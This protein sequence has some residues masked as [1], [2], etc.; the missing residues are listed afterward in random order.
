MDSS[1]ISL[2]EGFGFLF[3]EDEVKKEKVTKFNI[4]YSNKDIDTNSTSNQIAFILALDIVSAAINKSSDTILTKNFYSSGTDD[5][6]SFFI[7][8]TLDFSKLSMATRNAAS[9]SNVFG[10]TAENQNKSVQTLFDKYS[11]CIKGLENSNISGILL[12]ESESEPVRISLQRYTKMI[13]IL[14]NTAALPKDNRGNKINFKILFDKI[15]EHI[16]SGRLFKQGVDINQEFEELSDHEKLLYGFQEY[17][18][19][20]SRYQ[21][22]NIR[23]NA[24]KTFMSELSAG[25]KN[26][27]VIY[28]DFVGK[29]G[30]RTSGK[31]KRAIEDLT[32]E[33]IS[34]DGPEEL[35]TAVADASSVA[36][37]EADSKEEISQEDQSQKLQYDK[38]DIKANSKISSVKKFAITSAFLLACIE[39]ESSENKSYIDDIITSSPNFSK[40]FKSISAITHPDTSSGPWQEYLFSILSNAKSDIA[41][42]NVNLNKSLLEALYGKKEDGNY[43][44]DKNELI[45]LLDKVRSKYKSFTK[46]RL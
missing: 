33:L 18:K 41:K 13:M 11:E 17:L 34:A 14:K 1:K 46:S 31:M 2:K 23:M 26:I 39:I 3:E 40:L 22:Q 37:E 9:F 6:D 29:M 36:E 12:S 25:E 10:I 28:S 20:L 44:I 16:D 32:K 35:K 15:I 38:I 45:S 19:T 7:A 42:F 8:K 27:K 43:K 21:K 24:I 30:S 5:K 4:Q